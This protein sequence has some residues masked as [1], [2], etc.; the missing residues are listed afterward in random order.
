MQRHR[1]FNLYLHD[2]AE[3]APLLQSDILERVTLYQWP[4]S[5]VQ[6]L[7]TTD[8]RKLIYKSQFGP[9]VEP[10][11]YANAKSELLVSAETIHQSDG[12]V[13]MLVEYVK[14]PLLKDLDVSESQAVQI[15]RTLLA[16]I[17]DASWCRF[18]YIMTRRLL[19]I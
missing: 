1:F 18:S 10:E 8:G 2:D 17:A 16:K 12:H 5:C 7:T 13:S 9:T 15:G 14:A 4:L 3:L 6:R 19:T 11:F